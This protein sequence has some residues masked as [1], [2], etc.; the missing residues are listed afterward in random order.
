MAKRKMAKKT[1]A[2][3]DISAAKAKAKEAQKEAERLEREGKKAAAKEKAEAAEH[4]KQAKAIRDLK[5][6]A[7]EIN[8]RMDKAAKM[9]RDADDHRLAA[10]LKLATAKD[11]CREV[12]VSFKDWC[13]E[14]I[15]LG[16]QSVR[17]LLPIGAA[18][19]EEKGAGKLM[20]TDMREKNKS[21]NKKARERK[22]TE[23]GD[24]K[25]AA[26][27]VSAGQKAME[28]L[29]AM[30]KD[31]KKLLIKSQAEDM[32]MAVVSKTEAKSKKGSSARE[33]AE[34]AF[35]DL[36]A[37]QK[38]AFANWAADQIGATLDMDGGSA[39]QEAGWVSTLTMKYQG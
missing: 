37:K 19:S 7:K 33:T 1:A 36:G 2:Q 4:A 31:E 38:V 23:G 12:G 35:N 9:S 20:L 15:N 6:E 18:E 28:G 11:A 39:K 26:K 25:P 32:G 5:P 34:D 29:D 14:N 10:A 22:K 16:E 24:S 3:K 27:K 17:K 21:A 13:E 8:V 30:K